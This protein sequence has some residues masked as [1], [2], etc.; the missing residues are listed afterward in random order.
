MSQLLL[1]LSLALFFLKIIF[2]IKRKK[3]ERKKTWKFPPFSLHPQPDK[4][5]FFSRSSN[6]IVILSRRLHVSVLEPSAPDHARRTLNQI[7]HCRHVI[8]GDLIVIV[9][10]SFIR[11][12]SNSSDSQPSKRDVESRKRRGSGEVVGG[13]GGAEQS[14]DKEV[15]LLVELAVDDVEVAVLLTESLHFSGCLAEA[16]EVQRI[17]VHDLR[18]LLYG[19]RVVQAVG[20]GVGVGVGDRVRIHRV[21][22]VGQRRVERAVNDIVWME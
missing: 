16:S 4:R 15:E 14:V 19:L 1:S 22:G 3:K 12:S 7:W 9:I 13:G 17:P 5:S 2:V 10:A 20:V 8:T 11:S 21:G 6:L 18:V